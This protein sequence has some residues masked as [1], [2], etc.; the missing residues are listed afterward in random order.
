MNP[1]FHTLRRRA[2]GFSLPGERESKS[3][4]WPAPAPPR[5]PWW[6]DRTE[7]PLALNRSVHRV[8]GSREHERGREEMV[9]E[10]QE[11]QHRGRAWWRS[12]ESQQGCPWGSSRST[13]TDEPPEVMTPPPPASRTPRPRILGKVSCEEEGG[14]GR[15]FFLVV[16]LSWKKNLIFFS[17]EWWDF[18]IWTH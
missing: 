11:R 7:T 3:P 2:Q 18:N 15:R 5:T 10:L 12:E 13:F 17:S 1:G 4:H 9:R 14:G 6:E 16:C 8:A